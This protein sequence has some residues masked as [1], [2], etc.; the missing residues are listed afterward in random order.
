MR[1]RCCTCSGDWW[2]CWALWVSRSSSSLAP[3]GSCQD[4]STAAERNGGLIW[5]RRR[6][7]STSRRSWWSWRGTRSRRTSRRPSRAG[8]PRL[9]AGPVRMRTKMMRKAW[10]RRLL[11]T[12]SRLGK[13][14]RTPPKLGCMR[15]VFY[16]CLKVTGKLVSRLR[17]PCFM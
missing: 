15:W 5:N 9:A 4:T 17:H 11:R 10:S 16:Y 3:T 1:R 2:P 13:Y 12:V 8:L 7:R 14:Y 6:R